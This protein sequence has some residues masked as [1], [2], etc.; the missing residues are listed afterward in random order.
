M[1]TV[2]FFNQY[3]WIIFCCRDGLMFSWPNKWEH[4]SFGPNKRSV[5][6][7]QRNLADLHCKFFMQHQNKKI[8]SPVKK[9][10]Y[11]PASI[12]KKKLLNVCWKISVG[13]TSRPMS[14]IEFSIQSVNDICMMS[15]R[16]CSISIILWSF[17][18]RPRW[19]MFP[20][21]CRL[22]YISINIGE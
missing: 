9:N 18:F 6:L 7:A 20:G 14:A 3:R 2:I 1:S 10:L 15:V 13:A 4:A 21:R 12:I 22:S 16:K 17:Y 5:E 11:R 8:S 19:V